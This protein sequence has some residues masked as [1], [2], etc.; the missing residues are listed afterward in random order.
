MTSVRSSRRRTLGTSARARAAIQLD[1]RVERPR[2]DPWD[3]QNCLMPNS[4]RPDI[5]SSSPPLDQ[6]DPIRL[7]AGNRSRKSVQQRRHQF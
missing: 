2:V 1:V 6:F 7:L 5:D 4:D 3:V